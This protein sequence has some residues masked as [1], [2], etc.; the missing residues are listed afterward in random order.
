MD[1]DFLKQYKSVEITFG[2]SEPTLHVCALKAMNVPPPSLFQNLT[3]DCKPVAIKSRRYTADDSKFIE[4]ETKKLLADGIIE[5][6]ISPWRAQVL[7]TTDER[8]KKRMVIDY[9][10]TINRFTQL[11]AYPLPNINDMVQKIAQYSVFS[12]IDLR[13]AYHQIPLKEEDKPYTAFEASGRLY[14]FNR[15]PF[16]ITNGQMV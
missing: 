15:M 13:S 16:G 2:G 8:H 11:D 9:S 6:S 12:T 4:T 1:Q 14:Q 10:Q 3:P 7:V 5:P